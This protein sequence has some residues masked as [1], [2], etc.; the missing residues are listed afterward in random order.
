[1]RV[2]FVWDDPFLLTSGLLGGRRAM[3]RSAAQRFIADRL[4]Q[5]VEE[6]HLRVISTHRVSTLP[7]HQARRGLMQDE[8]LDR[9]KSP[10]Q[11]RGIGGAGAAGVDLRD[12]DPRIL[13]QSVEDAMTRSA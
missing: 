13:E 10:R 3:I 6:A 2:T 9:S 5:R 4:T 1:M 7:H 8:A 12:G 11:G